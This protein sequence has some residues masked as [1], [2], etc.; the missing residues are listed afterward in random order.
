HSGDSTNYKDLYKNEVELQDFIYWYSRVKVKYKIL[1]AGNHDITLEKNLFNI[2]Q[3]LKDNNII[4]LE[5]E[6]VTIEGI[7]IWGSPFTPTFGNWSFMKAR[8]KLGKIWNT[9]PDNTDIVIVHGP[10]KGIMDSSFD[11]NN[12]IERCGCN[13]LKNKILQ[14]QPKLFLSGHIHNNKD[15]INAGTLKLSAYK[16]IF[17]NGSVVTDG[18]F[19]TLS[20]QGNILEI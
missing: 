15:I 4:Y 1:I 9:I 17:S 6:S 7:K 16:T 12:Y 5:N 14:I 19:G 11:F 2:K 3:T 20:S 8:H 18:K 13:A 10:P